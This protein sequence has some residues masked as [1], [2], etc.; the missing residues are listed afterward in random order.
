MK[1]KIGVGLAG[2]VLIGLTTSCGAVGQ[3][4][5][6]NAAV[7]EANKIVTTWSG[8]VASIATDPAAF[9]KS[10]KEAASQLKTL[11]GK[12]D[13]D[14]AGGINDLAAIVESVDASNPAGMADI[15][16]KSQSAQTKLAAACS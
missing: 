15:A 12:Y 16:T 2:L 10:T 1:T 3:A 9:E 8:S 7:T 4:V 6:C 11:A 5:D 13:G 14:L